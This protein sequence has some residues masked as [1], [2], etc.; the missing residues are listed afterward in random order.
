MDSRHAPAHDAPA[1][2]GLGGTAADDVWTVGEKGAILH[3]DG[4]G[5]QHSPSGVQGG[6]NGVWGSSSSSV[7]AVGEGG[8]IVHWASGAW[9]TSPE[10]DTEEKL[11][12]VWGSS[13]S[14]VW[15]VGGAGATVHWNGSAWSAVTSATGD[16][17]F[18]VWGSGPADV[19]AV[20]GEGVII[21]WDWQHVGAGDEPDRGQTLPS[22]WGSGASDVWAVGKKRAVRWDHPPLRRRRVDNHRERDQRVP[23]ER[24]G[25][26]LGR[27]VGG[28]GRD[29]IGGPV[30]ILHSHRGV[31]GLPRT[32]GSTTTT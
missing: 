26:W 2:R 25:H 1:Q 27:R 23:P 24:L 31:S 20:G 7:W 5:W 21:H 16:D 10:S 18:G 9:S 22:V 32:P 13:A 8:T 11:M 3:H 14:D 12:S 4:H 15:A 6:L 30:D 19:W 17:L 28:P 29:T